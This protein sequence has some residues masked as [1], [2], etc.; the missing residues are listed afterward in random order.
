[1]RFNSLIQ[2]FP[3]HALPV[4]RIRTTASL[5]RLEAHIHHV[6]VAYQSVLKRST[7]RNSTPTAY[8][9]SGTVDVS[10]FA[11]QASQALPQISRLRK[12]IGPAGGLVDSPRVNQSS[13]QKHPMSLLLHLQAFALPPSFAR[14]AWCAFPILARVISASC[15]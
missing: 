7:A 12:I 8:Q 4:Q 5:L 2:Y 1:M 9:C 11:C 6:V 15:A 13:L 3:R 14:R 10:E